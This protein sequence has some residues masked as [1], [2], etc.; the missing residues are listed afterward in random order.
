MLAE[1]HLLVLCS[2]GGLACGPNL[3][4]CAV[5]PVVTPVCHACCWPW[6]VSF[7]PWSPQGDSC[8]APHRHP[9]AGGVLML[10]RRHAAGQ[11]QAG[12]APSPNGGLR[13]SLTFVGDFLALSGVNSGVTVRCACCVPLGCLALLGPLCSCCARLQQC[14]G[15]GTKASN[16][17]FMCDC[18]DRLAGA[19]VAPI[20]M[21]CC[22]LL[23]SCCRA[24]GRGGQHLR[25]PAPQR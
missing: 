8:F 15:C 25:V 9:R 21:P 14:L 7:V 2:A 23:C 4:A 6:P 10:R 22:A 1:L 18:F 17:L 16:L 11:V 13:A 5:Q 12:L 19:L 20:D 3:P 24:P